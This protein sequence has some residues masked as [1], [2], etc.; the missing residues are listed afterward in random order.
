VIEAQR[1]V[2]QNERDYLQSLLELQRA[3]SELEETVGVPLD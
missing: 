1:T 2:R 3:F